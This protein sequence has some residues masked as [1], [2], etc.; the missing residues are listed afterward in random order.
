MAIKYHFV[1]LLEYFHIFRPYLLKLLFVLDIFG[2]S[3]SWMEM[4]ENLYLLRCL[5]SVN[6][7][8]NASLL[9]V[10]ATRMSVCA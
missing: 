6:A 3:D 7:N 9:S 2:C 4:F 5:S 8:Q 10:N 1:C